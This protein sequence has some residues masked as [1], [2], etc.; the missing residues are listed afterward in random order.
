MLKS[1]RVSV[2]SF[3]LCFLLLNP[4]SST[5]AQSDR[6]TLTG[7]VTDRT[8]AVLVGVSLTAVDEATRL[9]SKATS[10]PSGTYTI[11]L[12]PVG[13]YRVTSEIKG[14]K[15]HIGANVAVQVNQT[16]SL[17]I[18][19]DVGEM[20]QTV[21]IQAEE[22]PLRPDTS[23]L[24]TVITRQEIQELPLVGQRE[25][26]NPTFFMTLVPGVTG[27]G[28]AWGATNSGGN[29]FDARYLSTTVSGSQSGSTEFHLD[30]SIIASAGE[31][32][33]DPRNV[34][35]PPDA[36]GG[37]KMITLNAPAEYGRSGGGIASF[38]S[39][40]GTNQLHGSLYEYFRN[41][42]LDARGFF[43]PT[44]PTNRQNEFG[45]TTGGPILKD[46]TFFFGWYNGFRMHQ[47][48][49]NSLTTVPTD[50]M[51]RGDLSD[52][53]GPQI[54]SDALG[55]PIFQGAIY[56]PLT[57][58]A[59]TAGQVDP[60]TGLTATAD[61]TIRDPFPGNMIPANRFDRVA[62]NI[63]P[64][65][66]EPSL[67]GVLNNFGSQAVNINRVNGWGTKLDHALTDSHKIFG[68]FVWSRLNTPGVSPYPGALKGAM[69][70]TSDIRIF[71]LSEDSI[72]RPN[73]INH[74]TFGFNR[75]RSGT[76]PTSDSLGWPAKI[77]LTGV[78]EQG[79]FPGLSID[80]LG[81]YGGTTIAY[82]AQNNFDVNESLSWIKGKHT[83]KFGFEYLKMM[84]NDVSS[85]GDTGSFTFSNAE[86]GLPNFSTGQGMASFLLGRVYSGQVNVYASSNYERSG[87]Y[88]AYA[89]DDFKLTPKF[90]LN[91]GLRYDLY[92][93]TVDKLNHLAWVDRTAPNPALGG[94]PGTMIFATPDRRTGVDQFNEGFAPRF[95]L[96]YTVNSK[97]VLRAGYGLFWAA[98]G[99][100]RAARGLYIQGYNSFNS[101]SGSDE[102]TPYFIFQEGWPAAQ[103]KSPPFIDP[104]YG[105][106]SGVHILDRDD[107]HPPYLQNWTLNI[108]RQLPGQ[109][110]LDVAYVGNKGT[111]LQSRL[112]PTNQMDPRYLSL[113]DLLIKD[114]ADPAVQ[115]LPVVQ[116]FPVDPA[117]G[118]HVP[119]IGFQSTVS[120]VTLGQALRPLPQYGEEGHIQIRRFYEG[121][122][123]ST[124]HALQ[125]KV[126]KR[127]SR[128]LS[129][130]VAYTWSKTLTDAESQFSEFSGFTADP[131][132]RK[133][134]KS[135]SI[136]DYPH[137]LVIH[138]AY[139]LP[140]GPGKRF[141]RA[142]GAAG[143]LLEG[144][145]IAGI[146]QYQSGGPSMILTPNLLW[147]YEGANIYLTRPNVMPGVPQKSAALL[148]GHFDPNRDTMFNPAAW[149]D[150]TPFTF[151]NGPRTY[152]GLRQFAYLNED[153]SILK[154]TY[155]NERVSVEFRADFL[156]IFNR[157]VFGLGTGGDQYGA[158]LN[159]DRFAPGRIN[160]QSNY[161]REIQFGLKINY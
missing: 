136:N 83:L 133:A 43:S 114:I 35:F 52:Y 135:Y 77:G 65:F 31:F 1:M 27:R 58:R 155:L 82:D 141:A 123:L 11:P 51:K 89:Q 127:F 86:T 60:S 7:T 87:Y 40:S 100:I 54:G 76:H 119:F 13:T 153:V 5:W 93:P 39:K 3:T 26:R 101:R 144:W 75:W 147:P 14:F 157:T 69:P 158:A 124:Y 57:T 41:D 151:G 108:Q 96:A 97:T 117:T 71:R 146:Q 30:G 36:V 148:S 73:L 12:L 34:G 90:T 139:E 10:G 125:L 74:A 8:G 46:K 9:R 70:N 59:V 106:N 99:Y 48:L 23:D 84:S 32:S 68:S 126:D 63:L 91:Y 113:G 38:T 115:A 145:K 47:A 129:F 53:L 29:S 103:F 150:P 132:N 42:A 28:T 120:R 66:P 138:Y 118:D 15:T 102:I 2:V 122:G 110:L 149:V 22:P 64:L 98:G 62:K 16:T 37:F 128:G 152:G 20:S 24:R 105:F 107:A 92:R 81:F 80:Q 61:A 116:T 85:G 111:R 17:D 45:A 109:V 112:M 67:P 56:D 160:S 19:M 18:V 78:N 79:V 154:R 121:T 50:A 4:V 94:F 143:K 72:L 142:E 104:R 130:L 6:G 131:Y 21:E 134:E 88:A 159:N 137:N 55:R 156:N 95:G 44:T 33:A 161:P 49:S 25:V 140:F